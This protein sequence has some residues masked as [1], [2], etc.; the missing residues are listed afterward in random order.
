MEN[1]QDSDDDVFS[2]RAYHPPAYFIS[3]FSILVLKEERHLSSNVVYCATAQNWA[4][5]QSS[6]PANASWR[7]TNVS[8]GCPP[9][10]S[11]VNELFLTLV[12]LRLNLKEHDLA[13]H[14][15]IFPSSISRVF[16]T[17]IVMLIFAL[18]C[19]LLAWS[20]HH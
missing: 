13:R 15:D 12:R 4:T 14:F 3:Y 7:E 1:I 5:K 16:I 8:Q 20:C 9:K 17:W 11:Q 18:V 10:L 19:F 6:D 2:T